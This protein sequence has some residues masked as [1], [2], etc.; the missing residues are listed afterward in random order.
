M[1]VIGTKVSAALFTI[2]ILAPWAIELAWAEN[3]ALD[4]SSNAP[5]QVG[6]YYCA[7]SPSTGT[8]LD[9]AVG[10]SV[11]DNCKLLGKYHFPTNFAAKAPRYKGWV[12]LNLNSIDW[13]YIEQGSIR[14]SNKGV[15]YWVLEEYDGSIR[16]DNFGH[17]RS[18]KSHAVIHCDSH[19]IQL[20]S[21]AGYSERGAMGNIVFT[22]GSSPLREIVQGPPQAIEKLLC[23]SE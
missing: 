2:A 12:P 14:K 7:K 5:T 1:R 8:I 9:I 20:L 19:M 17:A 18:L 21:E 11:S 13:I 22:N 15:Y 6:T 16:P 3:G 10:Q 4:H 23:E